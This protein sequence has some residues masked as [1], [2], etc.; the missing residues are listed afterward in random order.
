[1][2]SINNIPTTRVSQPLIRQRLLT[3]VQTEQAAIYRLQRQLST[4]QRFD[5]ASEDPNP[6]LRGAQIVRLLERKVQMRTN[7]TSTASLFSATESA[8]GNVSTQLTQARAT[9]LANLGGTST[10]SSRQAAA[11]QLD[12]IID[13]L[14]Q[15][16]NSSFRGRS[17]FAGALTSKPA[18]QRVGD[19]VR[20]LGDT[21]NLLTY[22]DL[23][24]L[25]ETNLTGDQTFGGLSSDVLGSVDFNP[26]VDESTPLVQLRGGQGITRGSVLVSDGTYSS[27]VD[28]SSATT[29]G[30]VAQLLAQHPPGWDEIPPATRTMR[31][32][33]TSLGLELTLD[34]GALSIAE[35]GGGTTAAE[36]G[37][38]TPGGFGPGPFNGGDVNPLLL[39]T[40]RL[41][42]LFGTRATGYLSLDGLD[43]DIRIESLSN[44]S[45][46]NGVTVKLLNDDHLHV[47]AG[48][49]AGDEVAQYSATPTAAVA[50]LS[51]PGAGNDLLLSAVTPGTTFNDVQVNV[52]NGGALGDAATVNYA[53][54]P[55][56]V[57]TLGIDGSGQTSIGALIA[58]INGS[59]V[60]T[61]ARDTSGGDTLIDNT[62]LV[63]LSAIGT[64]LANTYQ[65]GSDANTLVVRINAGLT[66]AN[67]VIEAI[68]ATGQFTARVDVSESNNT[69]VG[70][71]LDV[72]VDPAATTTLSGGSGENLDTAAG[73]RITNGGTTYEVNLDQVITV[74]D[75]LNQIN[76]LGASVR[77]TINALGTGIDIR[78]ELSGA[79]LTIGE[80]GGTT[81]TQLGIRSYST[82]TVLS[83]LNAGRGVR[84]TD[85]VDFTITRRDGVAIPIALR[86]GVYAT[87]TLDGQGNHDALVIASRTTGSA[88]N[89]YRV[90]ITDSGS[91]GGDS[92][93][94]VGNTITFQVDLAAG[95]TAAEAV[96][97]LNSNGALGPQFYARLDTTLDPGNNGSGNLAATDAVAFTEGKSSAVTLGDVLNI[98]NFAPANLATATPLVARFAT[99]GNG[100]ELVDSS[101]GG[102]TLQ[103]AGSPT[104]G[105]AVDLGFIPEGNAISDAPSVSGGSQILTGRDVRPIEV[106]G[107]FSALFKLRDAIANNDITAAERAIAQLDEATDNVTNMRGELG[108]RS[109]A[110][111]DL[112]T[113][114]DAEEVELLQAK[115]DDLEISFEDVVSQLVAR[116]ASYEAALRASGA[117]S[118]LT[119]L[120]FL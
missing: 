87:A 80:N 91:G 119:L 66:T 73:F 18:F 99:V 42:E 59:G 97:L 63:P 96:T 76:G 81:A 52:V 43:N 20:Y 109:Q 35:V 89:A 64:G 30:D 86:G 34:G 37:I 4:G 113:R 111:D 1:M 31:A 6:A 2:A 78:S 33:V 28:L 13:N 75:L 47:G 84:T 9:A 102:G 106:P 46:F 27:V 72:T 79:A 61:A 41:N 8:L 24:A 11:S 92:V 85:G 82:T 67:Q 19:T 120:N 26:T 49:N 51:L 36:L 16:A 60:F 54:G 5:L 65:S 7:L 50:A 107:V 117:I 39:R 83:E 101:A 74:D 3:Q 62:A 56:K 90:A 57:L 104:P 10:P 70:A 71:V 115:S 48:L 94:L 15:T 44:G 32:R 29:L 58:A 103:V 68:N 100:I 45:A 23:G 93:S 12:L 114:L 95:F 105:T 53:S 55:P 22:S 40:T 21:Q 25:L 112:L 69:G 110:L 88:G 116:Q 38:K 118:Q 17:L 98:I 14:V 108:V 77:A